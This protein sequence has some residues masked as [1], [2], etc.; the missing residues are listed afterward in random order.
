MFGVN[1]N[2][3]LQLIATNRVGSTD[4]QMRKSADGG[5]TWTVDA[6][7][8]S[9]VK[10]GGRFLGQ[11]PN[12]GTQVHAIAWDPADPAGNRIYVGTEGAGIAASFDGGATWSHLGG[13]ER[14]TA[15]S[16]FVF[17]DPGRE[18]LLITTY[19]RGIWKVAIP[20]ADLSITKTHHPDPAVAGSELY[21]D[22][23]VHNSGPQDT[24]TTT[25]VDTL[26]PE[27]RYV[28]NTLADPS[29]CT[30]NSAPPG[31]SQVV[32]CELGPLANG[33]TNTFTIKV[34]VLPAAIANTG[35]VGITNSATVLVG[36]VVDA[37]AADN[38]A[39]D[40]VIVEDQA[41]LEVTKLCKPDTTVLAGDPIDCTVFVDNHGP[42]T[43]RAVV[44]DDTMLANGTFV[45]SNEVPALGVGTPGCTLTAVT[46]GQRLTCR[47]GNLDPASSTS[48]GR[49][50]IT[51]RVT[52]TEGMDIDNSATVQV[53]PRIRSAPTTGRSC[54]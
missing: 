7:L 51:Y 16:S 50:T 41:D 33:A 43:A 49:A 29:A 2:N 30:V 8:T 12:T 5:A 1:P 20:Q 31:V 39:T 24:A 13:S 35:P 15:I 40:T 45:V 38:T 27:V 6:S 18:G 17:G 25:V 37:N 22:L 42:S 46:G 36:G 9:L 23:T 53:T 21:Y 28:T 10:L 54:P 47:L 26:P 52:S 11:D 4:L 32:T 19:G 44:V 48:T 34:T 14:A 3:P